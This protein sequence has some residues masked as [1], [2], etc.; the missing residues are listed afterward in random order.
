MANYTIAG[1]CMEIDPK[2]EF[3]QNLLKDY[4]T[5]QAAAQVRIT[6]CPGQPEEIGLLRRVGMELLEN[7]SGMYIHGAAVLYKGKA[8]L[9]TAPSGT[10]KSTHIRFWKQL[11]G[12]QAVILNGD[13]PFIRHTD[14]QLLVYGGP[15]RGKEGWGENRSAPLG[16]IFILRRGETDRVQRIDDFD[17]LNELLAATIYPEDRDTTEKLMELIGRILESVPIRVLYCT[18]SLSAAQTAVQSI[19]GDGP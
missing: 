8:Y 14:G 16:G 13:K 11:L 5:P 3:T 15:W 19:E 6:P 2:T 17:A 9:F 12:D 18:K 4:C 7:H 10:G 1:V